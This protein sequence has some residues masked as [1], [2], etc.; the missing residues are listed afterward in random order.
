[1]KLRQ[2]RYFQAVAGPVYARG[3]PGRKNLSSRVYPS[4]WSNL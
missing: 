1:M 3:A 4:I 2:S